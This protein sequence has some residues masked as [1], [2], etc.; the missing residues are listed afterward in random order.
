MVVLN[1]WVTETKR[2]I[3]LIEQLHQLG[4]VGQGSCEAVDLIN[5]DDIDLAGSNVL[6]EP[7]QGRAVSITAGESPIVVLKAQQSPAGM[8]LA[9]DISL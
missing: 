1:C 9:T 2:H 3:V 4:E 6:K 5:D 8:G 7:L